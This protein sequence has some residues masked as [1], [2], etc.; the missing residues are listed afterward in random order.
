MLNDHGVWG[1]VH[2]GIGTSM[3]LGGTTRAATHL[4]GIVLDASVELDG[5]HV[6]R[7]GKLLI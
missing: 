5:E 7:D 2:F 4:D 6:L 1:T 3:T